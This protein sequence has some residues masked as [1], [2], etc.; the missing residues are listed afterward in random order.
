MI[1]CRLRQDSS[2]TPW[3]PMGRGVDPLLNG[4]RLQTDERRIVEQGNTCDVVNLIKKEVPKLSKAFQVPTRDVV[5]LG[6]RKVVG[7]TGRGRLCDAMVT[8][9]STRICACFVVLFLFHHVQTTRESR[10]GKSGGKR[11]LLSTSADCS[12]KRSIVKVPTMTVF[13][14]PI[15]RARRPALT[16]KDNNNNIYMDSVPCLH[17]QATES[18]PKPSDFRFLSSQT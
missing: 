9:E 10:G 14:Y 6:G 4:S 8:A 3:L 1:N 2:K 11:H 15:S 18:K 7:G 17:Q 13:T 5:A 12:R 16:A